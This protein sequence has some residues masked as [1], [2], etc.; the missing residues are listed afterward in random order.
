VHL[1]INPRN[2]SKEQFLKEAGLRISS[3]EAT[4]E[5]EVRDP[6]GKERGPGPFLFTSKFKKNIMKIM[7]ILH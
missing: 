1:Y 7:K 4:A 5:A 3:D 6:P 2:M